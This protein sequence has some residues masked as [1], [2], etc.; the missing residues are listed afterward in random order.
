M[1]KTYSLTSNTFKLSSAEYK[2]VFRIDNKFTTNGMGLLYMHI[3]TA[4]SI[5]YASYCALIPIY[6]GKPTTECVQDIELNACGKKI[7]NTLKARL[8]SN[9]EG[10]FLALSSTTDFA[11]EA[12]IQFYIKKII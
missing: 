10:V 8:V 7:T 9:T 5:N 1:E 12:N 6:V 4:T 2:N 11:T 3:P